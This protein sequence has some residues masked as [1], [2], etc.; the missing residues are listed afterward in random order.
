MSIIIFNQSP[1]SY[2]ILCHINNRHIRNS[3]KH[4]ITIIDKLTMGESEIAFIHTI[5]F[6][7]KSC[8]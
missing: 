8:K 1:M 4:D 5:A 3:H 2:I 7:S 6:P